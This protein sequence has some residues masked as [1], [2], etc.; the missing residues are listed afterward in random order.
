MV[1]LLGGVGCATVV[2]APGRQV[3]SDPK[4]GADRFVQARGYAMHYVEDGVGH[5]VVLIPGAFAT[6]RA[7]NGV[8]PRLSSQSRVLAVDYLGV[9]GSDKPETGFRYT[10]EEQADVLAAMMAGLKLTKVTVVG[11]SYGGAVALNL[12]ARYPDLVRDVVCIEGGALI[13]PEV[14]N[15]GKLGALVEWP[16]LGEII[17]GFMQSG[18]FDT[19]TA[20]S[21][22]G[23]AWDALTAEQ[24][25][26]IVGI[27]SANIRTMSKASW[28]G[29]YQAITKRIDFTDALAGSQVRVLY[30]VGT[31]SKYRAVA[32][33]NVKQFETHHPKVEVIRFAGGIHDLHLQHPDAV[34]GA[35]LR[36]LGD[37]TVV[38]GPV[39]VPT[40]KKRPHRRSGAVTSGR[41]AL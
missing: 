28:T 3:Y 26:E 22:M 4:Y 36:L 33:M 17:W 8:V 24:R 20:R 39:T 10:I 29:I 27:V 31:D 21:I 32:E 5:P 2:T 6:Y 23:G 40:E 41:R 25:Q 7:W 15:Y 30:L 34:A 19:I 1:L 14:L 12:A 16:I 37:R 13:T 38:A 18:L 9:G 11:A 35:V